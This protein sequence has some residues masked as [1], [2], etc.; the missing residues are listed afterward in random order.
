VLK[1]SWI[2][3]SNLPLKL[4]ISALDELHAS[5][6]HQLCCSLRGGWQVEIEVRPGDG[7]AAN[8]NVWVT[9]ASR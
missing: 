5:E 6:L 7:Q 3:A 9:P 1:K 2:L 4:R 8:E